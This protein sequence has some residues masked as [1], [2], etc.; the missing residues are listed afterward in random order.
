MDRAIQG[1]FT[2]GGRGSNRSFHGKV[3]SMIVTTLRRSHFMPDET[4][5]EMMITDPKR[6][7]DTYRVG[8]TVRSAGSG[9]KTV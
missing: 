7:E 9:G 4:E 2:I 3:A 5:I 1:D 8:Q 6:W